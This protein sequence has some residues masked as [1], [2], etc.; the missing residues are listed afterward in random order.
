MSGDNGH[1]MTDAATSLQLLRLALDTLGR[2][3]FAWA[4]LA[5]CFAL[6]AAAV[7]YPDWKRLT[8]AGAFTVLVYLVPMKLRKE[9]PHAV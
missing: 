4:T 2:R 5:M 8:A 6:F 3:A 1:T 7:W 9:S